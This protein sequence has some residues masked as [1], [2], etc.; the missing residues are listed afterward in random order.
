LSF[1]LLFLRSELSVGSWA[2]DHDTSNGI[3]FK[4]GI[5]CLA[6][7]GGQQYGFDVEDFVNG[8]P[9]PS[10]F[11]SVSELLS[12]VHVQKHTMRSAKDTQKACKGLPQTHAG[13]TDRDHV[14]P[15]LVSVPRI[16][17]ADFLLES[18]FLT[19]KSPLDTMGQV[20]ID[21]REN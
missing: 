13:C 20:A 1:A 9:T 11:H 19:S 7:D 3:T 12:C 2:V 8:P 10:L 21:P 4:N 15:A 17:A 16:E 14:L 5:S 18:Y 6:C